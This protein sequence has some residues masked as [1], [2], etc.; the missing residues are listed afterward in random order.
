MLRL[1]R[2]TLP[3]Q[4]ASLGPEGERLLKLHTRSLPTGIHHNLEHEELA[5]QWGRQTSVK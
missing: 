5:M 3:V 4:G 2:A 1:R